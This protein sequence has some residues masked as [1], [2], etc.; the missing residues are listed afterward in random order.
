MTNIIQLSDTSINAINELCRLVLLRN[1]KNE[2]SCNMAKGISEYI[3]ANRVA[4]ERQATW[5]CRNLSFYKMGR[6][7]E[8]A[9]IIIQKN[10]NVATPSAAPSSQPITQ[11]AFQSQVIAHLSR[12]ERLLSTK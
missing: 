8:L 7:V 11:D 12:I 4:T 5:L 6:P 3:T 2:I 9:H 1:P 10:G